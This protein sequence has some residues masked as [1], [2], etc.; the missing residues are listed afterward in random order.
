MRTGEA[1]LLL[2]TRVVPCAVC[3][4]KCNG[5]QGNPRPTSPQNLLQDSCNKFQEIAFVP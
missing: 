4:R 5:G 2:H 1:G 3:C